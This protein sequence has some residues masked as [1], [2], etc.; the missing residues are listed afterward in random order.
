MQEVSPITQIASAVYRHARQGNKNELIASVG[1]FYKVGIKSPI[2]AYNSLQ[3]AEMENHAQLCGAMLNA[4]K[5]D[6]FDEFVSFV[7]H[8]CA[9]YKI[10]FDIKKA[11]L[12]NRVLKRNFNKALK[13]ERKM[14]V[15]LRKN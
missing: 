12:S 7:E 11:Q 15:S 10:W 2:E 3:K 14:L 6:L 5:P 13:A 4:Q 1:E 8:G 9:T